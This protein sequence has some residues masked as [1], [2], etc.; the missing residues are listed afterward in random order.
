MNITKENGI[1]LIA[2]VMTI[3]LI[4]ILASMTTTAGLSAFEYSK[5]V[6]FKEE[7][8]IMQTKVNELNQN[9]EY[10]LGEELTGEQKEVLNIEE[11]SNIIYDGKN[12][13][14]KQNIANGFRYFSNKYIK[15]DLEL[16]AIKREF[17]VNV[18]YRYIICP[19]GLEYKNKTYYMMEQMWDSLYNVSYNDKNSKTGSFEVTCINEGDRYRIDIN[20]IRY[21]G[22]INNWQIQYSIVGRDDWKTASGLTFYI[23]EEGSYYVKVGYNDVSLGTKYFSTADAINGNS[24]NEEEENI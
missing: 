19:Q 23:T 22:Y 3:V 1:T 6:E 15:E 2:L 21:E 7:L 11:I 12:D 16:N 18:E 8:K 4:L 9:E 13:E 10:S 14:E 24:S 20:N 5:Y 17:F